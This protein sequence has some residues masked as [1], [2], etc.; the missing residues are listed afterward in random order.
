MATEARRFSAQV[1]PVQR[2]AACKYRFERGLACAAAISP[3]AVPLRF[4]GGAQKRAVQARNATG[5]TCQADE[6]YLDRMPAM[7]DMGGG[8]QC[9]RI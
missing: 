6:Y 3:H 2:D 9:M 5:S 7:A 1:M 4:N 8:A